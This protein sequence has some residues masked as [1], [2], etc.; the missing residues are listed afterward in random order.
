MWHW[1][2]R[3]TLCRLN[4]HIMWPTDC[5]Y[6]TCARGCK[7]AYRWFDGFIDHGDGTFTQ[8]YGGPVDFTRPK[9]ELGPPPSPEQEQQERERIDENRRRFFKRQEEVGHWRD[10]DAHN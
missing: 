9:W 7:R 4:R 3:R 6:G 10:A 5:G 1:F 8:L 2:G